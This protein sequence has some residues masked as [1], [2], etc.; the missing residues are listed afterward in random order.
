MVGSA[1]R[2]AS[3]E[4][5]SLPPTGDLAQTVG[6][7]AA[8]AK[9]PAAERSASLRPTAKR[10]VRVFPGIC[11]KV[12]RRRRQVVFGQ[13]S[14]S[15]STARRIDSGIFG[16]AAMILTKSEFVVQTLVQTVEGARVSVCA[17]VPSALCSLLPK[18]D[19]AGS[20]PVAR[21][22]PLPCKGFLCADGA[23]ETFFGRRLFA[24]FKDLRAEI[25]KVSSE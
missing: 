23:K 9:R 20:N 6:R 12:P 8:N 2:L 18:L 24:D 13:Q 16:Q 1:P 11:A 22:K 15:A 17:P 4:A 5:E 10:A 25:G 21:S 14:I 7:K 19:V 3:L